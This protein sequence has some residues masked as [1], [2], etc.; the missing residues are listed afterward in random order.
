MSDYDDA[1]IQEAVLALLTV[2]SFGEGRS[3]KGYDWAVM[4]SLHERGLITNPVKAAKSVYL[5]DEGL[6]AGTKAA[7]HLFGQSGTKRPV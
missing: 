3:W 6:A 7:K 5:T 1:K 2:F 4:N